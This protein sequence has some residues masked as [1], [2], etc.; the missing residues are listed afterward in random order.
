[1]KKHIYASVDIVGGFMLGIELSD[2]EPD[3]YVETKNRQFVLNPNPLGQTMEFR[4]LGVIDDETLQGEIFAIAPVIGNLKAAV[5]KL[6]AYN[7]AHK[8]DQGNA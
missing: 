1:M 8:N 2:M 3:L 6:E 7:N 4:H 5:A